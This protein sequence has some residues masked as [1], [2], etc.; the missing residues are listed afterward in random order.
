[1]LQINKENSRI[2]R[3]FFGFIP[4]S[5][6]IDYNRDPFVNSF[7]RKKKTDFFG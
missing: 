1:M 7:E 4:L 2:M 3:T 5:Q 6:K